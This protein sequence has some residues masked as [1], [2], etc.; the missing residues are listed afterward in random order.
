M[1]KMLRTL[2]NTAGEIVSLIGH[3]IPVNYWCVPARGVQI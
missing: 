1:E 2:S 3:L